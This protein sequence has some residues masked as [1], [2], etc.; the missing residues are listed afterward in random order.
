MSKNKITVGKIK[1]DL[2]NEE[3]EDDDVWAAIN[4]FFRAN[5]LNSTQI[6][7]YN[8]FIYT[9]I[10][11]IIDHHKHNEISIPNK[12]GKYILEFGECVLT[13]PVYTN[14]DGESES[15]LPTMAMWTNRNYH[16]SL[17]VSITITA[18]SGV[19]THHDKVHIGDIPVMVGS[20]L[21]N[22]T[23]I[24]GDK[25]KLFANSEDLFDRGGYFITTP[26]ETKSGASAL[27]KIV[28][29]QERAA[30]KIFVFNNRKK[31]PYF[32]Y[33][34]EI[35]ST[36]NGIQV[37]TTTIGVMKNHKINCILPWIDAVEIPLG[38]VFKS[39]GID[40]EKEMAM[41]CLG[42][43]FQDELYKDELLIVTSSLEQSYECVGEEAALRY[44][45]SRGR[46]FMKKEEIAVD[47]SED[48]EQ[49]VE[50]DEED[51]M[52]VKEDAIS[53]ARHLMHHEFLPHVGQ[54]GD[55]EELLEKAKFLGVMV[56]KLVLV[57]LGKEKEDDRDHHKN[58]RL[59]ATGELLRQ[60]FYS[61]FRRLLMDVTGKTKKALNNGQ[62]VNI[63]SWIKP[64]IISNAMRGAISNNAWT[65][66]GNV[67]GIAQTY[68]QFNYTAGVANLR[69]SSI[70]MSTNGG[71]SVH[72]RDLHQGQW[73]IVCPAETPEGK[74]TGLVKNEALMSKITIGTDHH[75]IKKH[76]KQLIGDSYKKEYP[77]SLSWCRV[78]VNNCPVGSTKNPEEIVVNPLK[79]MRRRGD[80]SPEVS[81]SHDKKR[82]EVHVLTDSGRAC[83]PLFVVENGSLKYKL[84][85]AKKLK[86][87]ELTWK[88]LYSKGIVELIDKMEEETCYI[89]LYPS[90]IQG[91]DAIKF[92]HCEMHPSMMFGIGGSIIPFPDHNQSPRNTYQ[93]AM[94][95]QAIGL[96]FTN[97][98][99]AFSS[100]PFHTMNIL[101]KPMT[102]SRAGSIIQF[103]QLPAGQNAV[104]A[105]MPRPFNEEDSIEINRASIQRGFQV[106]TKWI[107]YYAEVQLD[108][109]EFFGIPTEDKCGKFK[110]NPEK[111]GEE[112][113]VK[114]GTPVE[115]GD[116]LIGKL[117]ESDGK[118]SNKSIK[119]EAS[120]PGYVSGVQT[121]KTGDGYKFIRVTVLQ[122]REP[123]V[124]DKFAA[125][126]GQK[127]TV[128]DIP[129]C[130]NLPYTKDGIVPDLVMNSLAFP[131]RMTIAMLIEM[132]TGKALCSTSILH[133]TTIADVGLGKGG[134]KADELKKEKVNGKPTGGHSEE[135]KKIFYHP[136]S[137][138]L[139]DA[140][141][142][143]KNFSIDV[144]TKEM[145]KYGLKY[146]DEEMYDGVTGKPL[147]CL[148]YVGIA[149]Y[150]RLR[151]MVVDKVHSRSKGGVTTLTRQPKEGR[152]LGGG[153][154]VG[155][156]ERDAI[157]GQ[158][159]VYFGKDRLMDQSD[160]FRD[161]VCGDCGLPAHVDKHSSIKECRVC[162][163]DNIAT[164]KK[165]FGTKLVQQELM[166]MNIVPKVF[167][168]TRRE[169]E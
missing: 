111:L 79:K 163:S 36:G 55:K 45:G 77:Q 84:S 37:T 24:M 103:D 156:M 117:S 42:P 66:G 149:Y 62:S 89:A 102:L 39:L 53:Y 125:R 17:M 161:K 68:D 70:P 116:F 5:G 98:A 58:K 71:G 139:G 1:K 152:A 114:P 7:S 23:P 26:K 108:K 115:N 97:A 134:D 122:N 151:H 64:A 22:L 15:L 12:E 34:A 113:F 43:S 119:Y 54:T 35:R 8:N 74:K 73:G 131:S 38:V 162:G 87:G 63:M 167:T 49:S 19:V 145:S 154:R 6:S 164:I 143:K 121:G 166:A 78:Y 57:M 144:L 51:A 33:Y 31:K 30:Q 146:G 44:I 147:K 160:E 92:T 29:P 50:D 80:I 76:V 130:E 127:G 158:G 83:R 142:F 14:P 135:F 96:P 61:G 32:S 56:K 124:G 48:D 133:S 46:K 47:N 109:N 59:V 65:I 72:P 60:Q 90:S 153:L 21:C 3:I 99:Q 126:H 25:E 52:K 118:I 132:L 129:E 41:L 100:T 138:G 69:K 81:I 105:V 27:K 157:Y 16:A 9:G 168:T 13:S 140:T 150:Q 95:K 18:P 165:P 94:G 10:Q 4:T 91:E 112:F 128:G 159:A 169:F 2:K 67:K 141:P 110:G 136:E 137:P 93:S 123:V 75:P 28:I 11:K 88:D 107:T 85:T 120:W 82:K 40:D 106:S 148:V 20:D 86:V 104:V 155:T 101:Q